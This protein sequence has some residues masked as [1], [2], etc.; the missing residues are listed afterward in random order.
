MR[1]YGGSKSTHDQKVSDIVSLSENS[2]PPSQLN[3]AKNVLTGTVTKVNNY[4]ISVAID[5]DIETIDDGLNEND[6]FKLLK[7][8]NE[9]TH[10]RIKGALISIKENKVNSRSS[11]LF[12]VIF[13]NCQPEKIQTMLGN[14]L[15]LA[16]FNSRLDQSQQN[17]VKFSFEQKDLA[18][19]HGPP[20][21]GKTTTLVEIIK[22]N[23]L[24]YKQKLL[25]CAPSNIAV[26]NLVERLAIPEKG[27]SKIKLIRLGHPARLLENIHQY[28]LDSVLTKSDQ[29]KLASDIK[30][31]MDKTLRLIRKSSTQK[32]E[33]ESLKR[34]MRELRKELYQRENRALKEVLKEADCILATLTT[35][36]SDGPLKHLTEDH[37]D[38]IIIDECS[39]ALEAACWIPLVRGAK[40]LILAG[41]HLQL[42]PTILSKEAA[43]K[44]LD[45]TLMKR[46]IDTYGHE[47]TKMLTIQYRMNKLINNWISDRLYESKLVAHETVAEH[48]LCDLDAIDKDE[49]TNTALVFIDTEGCDMPEMVIVDENSSE[50][51][52]SKANDGE[53]NVVCKH[54]SDLIKAKL[55]QQD[56]AVITPYNLQM[57]L[58]KAKLHAKFPNV[59]VKSV[60]GF[61]GREKEAII[62]SLVRSNSRGEVGFL[63]D[64]RRINVAITRARRH[65]CVV[66][67]SHT[68][69]NDQ[70]LK[71]FLDYCEQYG[72]IRSGFDYQGSGNDLS[73]LEF[74][75]IKFSKLKIKEHRPKSDGNKQKLVKKKKDAETEEDKVF[76]SEVNEI[77][78]KLKNGHIQEFSF[79]SKLNPK[80][81][82]IVHEMAEKNKIEHE[83]QGADDNRFIRI[84]L[85]RKIVEEPKAIVFA[86]PVIEEAQGAIEISNNFD[87][88]SEENSKKKKVKKTKQNAKQVVHVVEPK[89]KKET[90]C[91]LLGELTD[92][93]DSDLKFRS[94]CRVCPWCK[95]FILNSS[96]V[97]HQLHCSKL[98]SNLD[99]EP[100]QE[101]SNKKTAGSGKN[102]K[103]KKNPLETAK[104]DDFDELLEMFQKSN[105]VCNFQGCKVLVQTLGQNCEFCR[106]RFCLKHCL[107]EA[108]GCGDEAKAQARAHIRKT[109]N[110][111]VNEKQS[112]YAEKIRHQYNEKKLH[113][114]IET[115]RAERTG[116]NKNKD[117]K[118]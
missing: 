8:C 50:D 100:K 62:L 93:N 94:D 13:Q 23:C 91:Y 68:C 9:V 35:T 19:I 83:S 51:E 59:E 27:F 115:M 38:I 67:D 63:A 79:S 114:K 1:P 34:E 57:Q 86:E 44:G 33:R 97:M 113:E 116:S 7:L 31:D 61:Q 98:H 29:Y 60:D 16:F 78:E 84:Y 102:S 20:G 3:S 12:D 111:Q 10:K 82:R 109:G 24:K 49:N 43:V 2:V 11:H 88:L 17:A 14:E 105:S 103:V 45:L 75:D 99:V 30:S 18:I 55:K 104:T 112:S 71:S 95:K 48:L 22:Q 47:C 96:F 52:E 106:S 85:N 39:Q 65:L 87:G 54:V 5:N 101:V 40:K 92:Q 66:A 80:Q 6:T 56:I 25:I 117:K 108:H 118:N 81:R 110:L 89:A 42:P 58:I 70:F 77:I 36:H 69:K 32:C 46:L 53:A 64:Q 21:T 72:D 15:K 26:D 4:S 73:E 90:G 37:F 41:D 74:E 76:Q 107:A 28:S